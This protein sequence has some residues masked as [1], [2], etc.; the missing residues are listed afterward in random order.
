MLFTTE[1]C[2]GPSTLETVLPTA[3]AMLSSHHGACGTVRNQDPIF[4]GTFKLG[5]RELELRQQCPPLLSKI[6]FKCVGD[7]GL[8]E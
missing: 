5:P 7:K 8:M 2:H 1:L 4:P 6:S 3:W